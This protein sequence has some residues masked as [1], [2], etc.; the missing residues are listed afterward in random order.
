MSEIIHIPTNFSV[1]EAIII[2]ES[3][4]RRIEGGERDFVLDFGDCGFID[5]TGLGV[6]VGIHKRCAEKGGTVS[7]KNVRPQVAKI[8]EMTRL[9]K[10]FPLK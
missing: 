6:M 2:R 4:Y 8:L 10:V 5:S 7:V 3:T 9:D 1:E